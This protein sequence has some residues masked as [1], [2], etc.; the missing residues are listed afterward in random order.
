MEYRCNSNGVTGFSDTMKL[1]V[2]SKK[3]FDSLTR[4]EHVCSLFSLALN[5]FSSPPPL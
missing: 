5:R 1:K 3:L 4:D 2:T